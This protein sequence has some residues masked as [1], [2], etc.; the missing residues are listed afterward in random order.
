MRFSRLQIK[1]SMAIF[2][3][4]LITALFFTLIIYPYEIKTRQRRVEEIKTLLRS[5]YGQK[6]EELA[7]ELF[8]EHKEALAD[9][10][11][12]IQKVKGISEI[13]VF[14]LTGKPLMFSGNPDIQKPLSEDE[15]KKMTDSSFFDKIA[16]DRTVFL[17]YFTPIRVMGEHVGFLKIYFD[18]SL[19]E[20]ESKRRILF[21]MV[22]FL[23]IVI[24][25]AISLN[26]LLKRLV[27]LPVSQLR[28]AMFK[29]QN[30]KPGHIVKLDSDDEIGEMG[31]AFNRMSIRLKNQQRDL[32]LSMKARDR[33][34]ARLEKSNKA[35]ETLNKNLEQM[36]D[37]RTK[38]LI[39]INE[40]LK[41]EIDERHK[42]DNEKKRLEERLER[43][44]KMESLGLLA[45]GVA[46]DLNNVLSGIV[47]YPDLLLMDLDDGSPLKKP[48]EIIRESGQKAAAIVQ[49]LLTLA[50]RGVTN[51]QILN[52]NEDIIK[53]YLNS[54]EF[55][56]LLSY[57]PGVKIETDLEKNLLN[58]KGS[59]IHLRKTL[60]NLVSN[61]AEAQPDGGKILIKTE[62]IYVDKAIHGYEKIKEGDYVLLTVSDMGMGISHEDLNRIFEPFYTKKAMGRSGTGLGMAVVWGTIQDHKGYINV[63]SKK[64]EGTVFDLYFPV[65]REK[66]CKECPDNPGS[67]DYISGNGE[68]VLVVDDIK[69]QRTI[70]CS[71]LKR[72]GY[73]AHSVSSGEQA[74]EYIKKRPVHIVIL[75]MVM[76]G[77]IDGL[78]T[79]REIISIRP[80]QKAIIAS[81]FAENERVK[82]ALRLGAGCYIKKPYTLEIIGKA[83]KAELSKK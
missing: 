52:F 21:F 33:Y 13:I 5:V 66:I 54:P 29:V 3:T 31:I 38:A 50:R 17:V 68:L 42:A 73:E 25:M 22:L 49:D 79:Y 28:D 35:L 74:I 18:L 71:I 56:K 51:T 45:G 26:L 12:Q 46:H 15:I 58:I 8:A 78:D 62:N 76:E 7:N 2:I 64:G 65:T 81:G 48:I 27:I 37:E 16:Q 77:G 43:S 41:K 1:I 9:T 11:I 60:M 40:E 30:G 59:A 19:L 82:E 10:L 39:K 57:H 61:A 69:D 53:D 23:S 83:I 70:A 44:R 36:V 55:D 34:F 80:G 6:R 24:S 4:S 63:Y 67:I 32:I 14:D 47:S 75:D 72:I 20:K